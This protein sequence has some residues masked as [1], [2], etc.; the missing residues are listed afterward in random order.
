MCNWAGLA[1][2]HWP[3]VAAVLLPMLLMVLFGYS[4]A[5]HILRHAQLVYVAWPHSEERHD[6]G[7]GRFWGGRRSGNWRTKCVEVA[8]NLARFLV[9]LHCVCRLVRNCIGQLVLL[10]T[11][12]PK[13]SC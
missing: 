11:L 4:G 2:I 10:V 1:C 7:A 9:W 3:L 5:G 12:M 6:T 8:A 13:L